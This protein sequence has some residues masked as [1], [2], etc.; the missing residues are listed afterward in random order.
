[1]QFKIGKGTR[2][3]MISFDRNMKEQVVLGF[4][5]TSQPTWHALN[6]Y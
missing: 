3:R 5:T 1:M 6:G 4:A 2:K